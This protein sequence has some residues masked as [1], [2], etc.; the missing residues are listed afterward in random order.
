MS[1]PDVWQESLAVVECDSSDAFLSE[2]LQGQLPLGRLPEPRGLTPDL[3][4]VGVRGPHHLQADNVTGMKT[5]I[6][7]THTHT[8]H[9]CLVL[10]KH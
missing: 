3:L 10:F 4:S 5:Q 9:Y 1:G 2:L 6:Q 7:K 8:H